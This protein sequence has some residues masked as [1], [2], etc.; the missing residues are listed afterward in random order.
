MLHIAEEEFYQWVFDK[1]MLS[2]ASRDHLEECAACKAKLADVQRLA[3]E[4]QVAR[5]SEPSAAALARY[6]QLYDQVEQAP[7]VAQRLATYLTATLQWDG[8]RQPAWQGLRSTAA[9]HYRLL[10]MTARAE[11]ELLVEPQAGRFRVIGEVLPL[12]D[13]DD[14]FPAL[15]ELQDPDS[16][17][18]VAETESNEEGHFRLSA[19]PAGHYTLLIIPPTGTSLLLEGLEIS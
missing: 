19:V 2:T 11:V 9:L 5:A 14:L 7:S 17:R 15:L 8:R 18:T 3:Q 1:L 13:E 10:Y 4:L 16:G 6:Q 12:E